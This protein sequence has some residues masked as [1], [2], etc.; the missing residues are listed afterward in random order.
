[1]VYRYSIEVKF[2]FVTHPKNFGRIIA[3]YLLD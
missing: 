3:L 1:M 2:D